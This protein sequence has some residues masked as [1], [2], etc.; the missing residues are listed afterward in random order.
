VVDGRLALHQP[1]RRTEA[2]R[3]AALFA[4]RGVAHA[5]EVLGDT[6]ARFL[7]VATPAGF[8]EFVAQIVRRAD[9]LRLPEPSEPDPETMAAVAQRYGIE[10]LGP[11][12]TLP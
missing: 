2:E 6:P 9:G 12:G 3:G 10:L 8:E 11:P 4:E 7:V 5:Y 1:G